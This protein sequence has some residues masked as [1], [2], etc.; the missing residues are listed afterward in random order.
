MSKLLSLENDRRAIRTSL[1]QD[2][3]PVIQRDLYRRDAQLPDKDCSE[4][5]EIS[6]EEFSFFQVYAVRHRKPED[7][8]RSMQIFYSAACR[9]RFPLLYILEKK[10]GNTNLF[11]GLRNVG[12]KDD[13]SETQFEEA[14]GSLMDS[15][16]GFTPG[17]EVGPIAPD[18]RRALLDRVQQNLRSHRIIMGVPGVKRQFEDKK[19]ET[20]KAT[21]FG[22]ERLIDSAGDNYI[23][24]LYAEPVFYEDVLDTQ[25]RV[26]SIH[27]VV[28]LMVKHTQQESSSTQEGTSLTK[29]ISRTINST[30]TEGTSEGENVNVTTTHLGRRILFGL[31]N[32]LLGE[33]EPGFIGKVETLAGIDSSRRS[34]KAKVDSR[35]PGESSRLQRSK[36]NTIQDSRGEAEQQGTAEAVSASVTSGKTYSIERTNEL[37]RFS[38]ELL[39]R[40]IKRLDAGHG[41]GMWRTSAHVYAPNPTAADRVFHALV[42]LFSTSESGVSPMRKLDVPLHKPV[43]RLDASKLTVDETNIF[44]PEYHKASTLITSDEL[45]LLGCLP[46]HEVPG[47]IVEKVT[48]YG[49]NIGNER[50]LHPHTPLVSKGND[51]NEECA[52]YLDIPAS[53]ALKSIS[54]G[55]LVDREVPT[56]REVSISEEQLVRHCFV[57]GTTGSGKS[58]TMRHIALQLW[59][60]LKIPFMV[61]E[62]VK[63][64]Y[65]ELRDELGPDMQVFTLGRMGDPFRMNPFD[66]EREVGLVQHIDHL[67]AAFNASLGTYSSMPYILEDI[68]YKVYEESGWDLDNG[69]NPRWRSV[70]TKTGQS[71]P[72]ECFLP[73]MRSMIPLVETSIEEFFPHKT[74][75]GGSL[76]GAMKARLRSMTR[77]AKG[78]FLDG[79]GESVSFETL[80]SKPTVLELSQFT[81]NDEKAFVMGL[82]LVKLYEYRQGEHQRRAEGEQAVLK[83]VLIIEEAHRLLAK[84]AGA[85]ELSNR[86]REKAVEVFADILAEIR[87]YG[88]GIVVVDQIPSKLIPDVLRNTDVK[89]A[90]RLVEKED[91]QIIGA[92][93]N[94]DEEQI[95]DLARADVGRASVYYGGLRQALRIQVNWKKKKKPPKEEGNAGASD[96]P[97]GGRPNME[98]SM[99]VHGVAQKALAVLAEEQQCAVFMLGLQGLVLGLVGG[100][101]A[102]K[103]SR[104]RV[105]GHIQKYF[106][107]ASS[108]EC[109]KMLAQVLRH[110]LP[111]LLVVNGW[112]D[113]ESLELSRIGEDILQKWMTGADVA[114][115]LAVFKTQNV[116]AGVAVAD[117]GGSIPASVLDLLVRIL[118]RALFPEFHEKVMEALRE[119]GDGENNANAVDQVLSDYVRKLA[120]VLDPAL[121][122][123]AQCDLKLC[124]LTKCESRDTRL[125]ALG[126]VAFSFLN[127]RYRYSLGQEDV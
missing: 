125:Q 14:F 52:E 64:E 72:I 60:D 59:K 113:E 41:V 116:W 67:K 120:I 8:S 53:H 70:C 89:I 80:L 99:V 13:N 110:W 83:H 38:E 57:T 109:G 98:A 33:D 126:G 21:P 106:G 100:T 115:S 61:I 95:K 124:M 90:H 42:G 102:L 114:R 1:V 12:E 91:R 78:E 127:S 108:D 123:T 86:G 34:L 32:T 107:A 87:S 112:S 77:G 19:N 96:R 54:L 4:H 111:Q 7:I 2:V 88:Q 49:R 23:L 66:F 85:G 117:A 37:A 63:N 5:T 50:L 29:N 93:M 30:R 25:K 81:D 122:M 36:Q 69:E 11:F 44:G 97:S 119:C 71:V 62:P 65:R 10:D 58:T 20:D 22:L 3:L 79:K 47:I 46:V 45:A 6:P 31:K 82:L 43:S 26:A 105:T 73:K 56:E 15:L 28:H 18:N 40:M 118:I 9:F 55:N 48:D 84:P 39:T 92:T 104:L 51:Q 121:P 27:D 68:V 103:R 101:P 76:L 74:D 94:L 16:P 35:R 24:L 17:C 75:Y